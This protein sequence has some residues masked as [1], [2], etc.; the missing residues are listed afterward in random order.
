MGMA[1]AEV[2]SIGTEL[3][4][5]QIVDTNA[6]LLGQ[7]L[8]EIGIGVYRR[9]TVGDNLPRATEAIQRALQEADVVFT[10]GGLGPTEDDLTRDAIAEATGCPLIHDENLAEHLRQLF[11]SR[12]LTTN[13]RQFRQA[14]RPEGSASLPNPHGTAPGIRLE[15]NGQLIYALPGPRH[16]FTPM[17]N[18]LVLPDLAK[19]F[20]G[21]AIVSRVLR[22][23]GIGE[24]KAEELLG[25]LTRSENP[26]LAPLA[27]I[28]E[29]H[30]RITARGKDRKQ[31]ENQIAE[32]ESKVRE[33]VGEF[34]YGIDDQTLAMALVDL[35]KSKR[36]TVATAESCTGGLLGAKLTEIAGSSEVFL[37]GFVTYSNEMKQRYLGVPAEILESYGAVSERVAQAMA[38]GALRQTGANWAIGITGI[39]GPGGG[40]E[41]KPVGLVFIGL[42]DANASHTARYQFIGDRAVV[43]ERAV[44]AALTLLRKAVLQGS[45]GSL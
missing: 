40:S 18:D 33:R 27:H 22:L 35:L 25:E 41:E 43:R 42:A 8:A 11:R 44:Q 14:M 29:T 5:G 38:E 24:S 28:A 39:A 12:G 23:T 30:F 17:L 2:V 34:V 7:R 37:G 13:D 15:W 4:L 6:P 1:R 21:E 36:Q 31:A 32:M 10:I 26:T 19:R 20:A 16:E 3:L 45:C 9:Y